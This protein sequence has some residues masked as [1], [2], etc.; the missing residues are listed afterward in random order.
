MWL[1]VTFWLALVL[2]WGALHAWIVPRIGDFRPWIEAQATR[3][4]GVPVRIGDIRAASH[5]LAPSFELRDVVL[6]DAQGREALRLAQV[7][8][9]LSPRSLWHL[10]FDQLVVDGPQL[11]ARRG[12]DGA[13]WVAG[14][15]LS[16]GEGDSAAADWF[17]RQREF[18]IRGGTVHWTDEQRGLAP[19]VLEQVDLVVRNSA[20]R[21]ALRLDATPP[22]G[23]GAR[24]SVRGEFRQPLLSAHAG[25]WRD[26]EG[27]LHADF[28]QID[29]EPL[30]RH[31][32]VQALQAG[33][34]GRVRAWLDVV[35]GQVAGGTA[36]VSLQGARAA[37]APDK[38]PL[39]LA[40]LSGRLAGRWQAGRL[41]LETRDLQ[42]VT[43][44]GLRWPGGNLVLAWSAAQ[45]GRPEQGSLR[46][47]RLDLAALGQLAA[48]LPLEP[49][50]AAALAA[51]A[52]AGL[53]ETVQARWQGPPGRPDK[54]E[55]R[56]RV[57]GLAVG[58]GPG[59][60]G[61]GT[62]GVE[63]ANIDF[64]LT[65]EGGKVRLQIERGAVALPGVL[66]EARIPVDQLQAQLQWQRSGER[67]SLSGSGL[68]FSNA[69]L[70]GEGQFSWR[71]A[72]VPG[73]RFPG[74]L[75][76]QASLARADGAR[77]WRYL[78]LGVPKGTRD[79][80]REAVLAGEVRGARV[81]VRGDLHDFPFSDARRGEFRISAPVR[82]A[83]YAYAPRSLVPGPAPW[84]ALTGLSGEL[85]FERGGLRVGAAQGRLG[86]G[87]ALQVQ[88]DASI[89]DLRNATVMVQGQVRGPLA[90]SL[91]V[92]NGSPLAA[93]V[94]SGLARASAT[95]PAEVRLQ[96]AL[97]LADLASAKMQGSVTLAGNDVQ[98]TPDSPSLARARGVIGFSE[99]GF[100][101]A[102]VQARALG[103]EVRIE[104]GS[105]QAPAAGA[106]EPSAV[107]RVQGT[108]T[109]EGLRQAHELGLLAGLARNASGG[110]AYSATIALRPGQPDISVSSNL[111]GLALGL[112][113]P[114]NKAA[115]AVLPLRFEAG[116]V[117]GTARPHDRWLLELGRLA[118]VRYVRDV[119]GAEPQ[120]V[121]GAIAVGLEAG[122]EA[123]MPE[124]GVVANIH[125]ATVDVDAWESV[126]GA[127]AGATPPPSPPPPPAT[128]GPAARPADPAAA[129]GYLPTTLAVRARA[130]V[131]QGRTL[132]DVVVGGSREGLT[133]RANV[134]A[135]ELNGY[136]EYRQSSSGAGAGRLYA[137]LTRLA[138]AAAAAGE[139]EAI[140]EQQPQSSIPAL[141]VVVDDFELRGKKLGRLEIDAVNR[142]PGAVAREGGIRE[143]RLNKLS[144]GMPEA[145]FSATGNWAALGAQAVVPGGPPAGPR[146]A[147]ER[148]RS[149]MS[150][151][152]D[153]ADAGGLL[154]RLGM[155]GVVQGGR[156]R[157]EGQVAWM[158]SPLS[159]DYP[160]LNGSF[161]VNVES[162]Q[163]L[164]ADPGLAKLL[165]VL[166]LQSLPR[167][168]TLDFRDVFS[169]G[170]A[171]DFVRGDASIQQ[172]MAFTNNLQ[173]KGINAAVLMEGRADIARETQDIRVVVVPEINAGTA[174]LVATVIN[175]AIGLG[176]FL[177]QFFLRQPLMRAATQEF[178][179][180]GT[181]ADPRVTRV[182]RRPSAAA[183]PSAPPPAQVQGSN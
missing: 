171:F 92:V 108:A 83:V 141:D 105:R 76:L 10:G 72:D 106:S 111:Q 84:P 136:V 181:W 69:D 103:G 56:G 22:A 178:L 98:I 91:A 81:R 16:S 63:G 107:L 114:L 167:R 173:M 126:L 139:V 8:G 2:A 51:H 57:T 28:Q 7:R 20:R 40:T 33:G 54:Y 124:Q 128:A 80:V 67:L 140:L 59:E 182:P 176:T 101:L 58:P 179:V 1:L 75:D 87:P 120:V 27:Q 90:E 94:G 52:P 123:P 41:E 3:A 45:E 34:R 149:V 146:P 30:G 77:V 161:A 78:P 127:A 12:A 26:W 86:S 117:H 102:G 104:G 152:L 169:E 61:V 162:G 166:S 23:W 172:G 143:W 15:R 48:H 19:V 168:L 116:A 109:A 175:P 4:L 35:R 66:E 31:G 73:R 156:G 183:D 65:E 159:P 155:P 93:M 5:G 95:G 112:P 135:A 37:L 79:Y 165:S 100:S 118:S 97:P 163:F 38:P 147:D 82:D 115:E 14:L 148:R 122:E 18:V 74:V 138:L 134:D 71:T 125:L 157:L 53:V 60:A 174:S 88:A 151:R 160:S 85:V 47:D 25:R 49:A 36:D 119:S 153:L 44:A 9:A 113:P 21:H 50:A 154:S 164:K 17:F 150:F 43:E 170:F 121:R 62:P 142:G 177:A 89:P 145:T 133:W 132:H 129:S 6:L 29:L 42:F 55:A 180:D 13:W 96:L 144:L 11:R 32:P 130:L 24:F 110:A 46:A 137:R 68:R 64:D 131:A 158:G 99:R 70:Q 39:A